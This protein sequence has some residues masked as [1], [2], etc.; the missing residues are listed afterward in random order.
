MVLPVQ[1]TPCQWQVSNKPVME[2]ASAV[3]TTVEMGITATW[4]EGCWG[5]ATQYRSFVPGARHATRGG[6]GWRVAWR[7]QPMSSAGKLAELGELQSIH[8]NGFFT[9]RRTV[10][11]KPKGHVRLCWE[12]RVLRLRHAELRGW[13]QKNGAEYA[14]SGETY[15]LREEETPRMPPR[16]RSCPFT[17][18]V[19]I[20]L[21]H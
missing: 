2:A 12:W 19:N 20:C 9:E 6:V 15:A 3:Y 11:L 18:N 8:A 21:R 13:W 1:V 17:L 16:Q 14:P 5:I 7:T 4:C 10:R